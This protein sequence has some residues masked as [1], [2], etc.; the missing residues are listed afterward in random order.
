M[1]FIV[2]FSYVYTMYFDPIYSLPSLPT[3]DPVPL[4][5]WSPFYFH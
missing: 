1:G 5:Q 3:L 4:L 2:I